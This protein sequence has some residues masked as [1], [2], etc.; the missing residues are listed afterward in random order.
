[1]APP[2]LNN[3][4]LKEDLIKKTYFVG[5]IIPFQ[6]E[7]GYSMFRNGIISCLPNGKWSKIQGKCI[8]EYLLVVFQ[9]MFKCPYRV[10]I[11]FSYTFLMTKKHQI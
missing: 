9:I 10:F 8:S 6:C 11:Y 1:M 3:M 5:N 7:D 4:V 2:L